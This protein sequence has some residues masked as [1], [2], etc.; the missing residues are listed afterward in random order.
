MFSFPSLTTGSSLPSMISVGS[1][2]FPRINHRNQRSSCLPDAGY[3]LWAGGGGGETLRLNSGA[4]S[5]KFCCVLYEA[6]CVDCPN[7]RSLQNMRKHMFY[8]TITDATP[9]KTRNRE[10]RGE[11]RTK[12]IAISLE[13]RFYACLYCALFRWLILIDNK[14]NDQELD[15]RE[16][17]QGWVWDPPG[18]ARHA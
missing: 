2:K 13:V 18:W 7:P 11:E 3:H 15:N 6:F 5:L 4:A 9:T 16:E 10:R 17:W 1:L 12:L 14:F 8:T